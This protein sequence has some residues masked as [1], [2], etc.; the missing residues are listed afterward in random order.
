MMKVNPLDLLSLLH[1]VIPCFHCWM[2]PKFSVTCFALPAWRHW[3]GRKCD[4]DGSHGSGDK[5]RGPMDLAT[6]WPCVG[7][8]P[9]TRTI[10]SSAGRV[11][12]SMKRMALWTP[13][14]PPK[15]KEGVRILPKMQCFSQNSTKSNRFKR[16]HHSRASCMTFAVWLFWLVLVPFRDVRPGS[17]SFKLLARSPSTIRSRTGRCLPVSLFFWHICFKSIS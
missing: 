1:P 8:G 13:R 16:L 6:S 5:F 10:R 2:L 4:G 15:C 11:K 7:S 9:Q 12:F 3:P 14:F 17:A